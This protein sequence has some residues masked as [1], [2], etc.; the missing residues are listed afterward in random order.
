MYP[1]GYQHIQE[2][3]PWAHAGHEDVLFAGQVSTGVLSL[4]FIISCLLYLVRSKRGGG[5]VQVQPYPSQCT[6]SLLGC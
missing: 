1:C 2:T 6:R 5:C 4:S 3:V